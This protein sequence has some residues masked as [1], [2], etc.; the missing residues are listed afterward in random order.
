MCEAYLFALLFHQFFLIDAN[1]EQRSPIT[2]ICEFLFFGLFAL[3]SFYQI[4]LAEL[5]IVMAHSL[6]IFI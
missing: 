2:I 5:S 3:C 4:K 6:R 1:M